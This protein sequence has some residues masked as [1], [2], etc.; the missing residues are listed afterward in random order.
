MTIITALFDGTD[1]WLGYNDGATIG[2]TVVASVMKPWL[3]F[4]D[5]ALGVTGESAQQDLIEL[6]IDRLQ[7]TGSEPLIITDKL[8][9]VFTD[10]GHTSHDDE[11]APSFKIWCILAHRD[12]RIWDVDARL[13]ITPIPQGLLWARGSGTD[14]A[15]GADTVLRDLK[16]S[17]EDRV[18]KATKAAIASDVYCAGDPKVFRLQTP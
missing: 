18:I 7:D 12:G 6:N 4:D 15:L 16:I 2:D 11:A 10:Y 14:F 5:W 9:S 8:R 1:T 3:L 13:A 17:Q